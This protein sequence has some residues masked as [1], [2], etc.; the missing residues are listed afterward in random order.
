MRTPFIAG[1]WKMH[2]NRTET[3]AFFSHFLELIPE[4]ARMDIAVAPPYT[5]IETARDLCENA[6]VY[7]GAQNMHDA[8]KGAFTGE[9]SSDMLKELGVDFVILGHSERRHVFGEANAMISRKVKRALE[10]GIQP[11]FCV[12]ELLAEREDERTETVIR[13]QLDAVFGELDATK[14]GRVIIA[15]EP[16]WAIGTGKTAT[17]KIAGDVH[18]FIRKRIQE[19]YNAL[20]AEDIRIIYGGSVKP[21]NAREL[22][23]VPDID[24]ALVGGASLKAESFAAIINNCLEG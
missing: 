7:I 17:P 18:I 11:V 6:R 21:D 14:A 3:R 1:N 4:T 24:G 22:L 15:Y 2:M 23:A 9:I 12:G 8:E 5:S 16:V 10:A 19:L 20:V 13:E